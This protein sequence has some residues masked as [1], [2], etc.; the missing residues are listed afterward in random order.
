MKKV[1]SVMLCFGMLATLFAGCSKPAEP[2]APA[3]PSPAA[4][5]PAPAAEEP[6][7][8]AEEPTPAEEPAPAAEEPAA[9][10]PAVSAADLKVAGVV[11]QE[12]QFMKL[13]QM[14]YEDAA[15]TAGATFLPGNTNNDVGKESELLNT[16]ITQGING[17]AITPISEESSIAALNACDAAGIKIG[18]SNTS[19]KDA[20]YVTGV[21]T[22]DNFQLGATTGAACKK[23]IEEKLDGKAKI[24]IL[25]FK[26]LLPEQSAARSD[27]F[28]SELKDMPG[29]EVVA[30]QDAW[31]QDK[32]I[33]VA[34]DI[35]TAHPDI[36]I[37]FAA[38]EGGTIGAS[39]AV[40]NAGLA[41]KVYVF[42]F[43]ASEQ[44][45]QLLQ[46]PDNILQAV[47]GQDPYQI[48]VKTMEQVIKACTGADIADTKG[49]VIIVPGTLLTREDPAALQAFLDDLKAKMG[50]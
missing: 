25:Q 19:Y 39:M 18:L 37:L 15:K 23:F 38:N 9:E 24:G 35:L 41:G 12:D 26:S 30:D 20:S 34:G 16:Y 46:D 14:G 6:A 17:I 21:F 27:G 44:M 11:F 5:A 42:G 4:E 8:A 2:E 31:L 47:T 10:A 3:E 43:D 7:P 49:Q 33:T 50:G 40:K 45:I 13:L 48:G 22:S 29:V 36:N 32:A 1:L 28:L